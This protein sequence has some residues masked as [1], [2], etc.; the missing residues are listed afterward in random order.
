MRW[1]HGIPD[2]TDMSLSKSWEIVKDREAWLLVG[3]MGK[4]VLQSTV[5]QRVG[6]DLTKGLKRLPKGLNLT[7]LEKQLPR[8]P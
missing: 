8:K 7:L 1:L 6:H 5:L 4:P 2:T 3:S